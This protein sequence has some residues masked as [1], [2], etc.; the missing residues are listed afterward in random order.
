[1]QLRTII[2][3]LY[4]CRPPRRSIPDELT[5]PRYLNAGGLK[6]KEK[7][8][9][10]KKEIY[11]KPDSTR[12]IFCVA[13][14]IDATTKLVRDQ[15]SVGRNRKRCS[16]AE[17]FTLAVIV[18]LHV[19]FASSGM[20]THTHSP[21]SPSPSPYRPVIVAVKVRCQI[22][23]RLAAKRNGK[24]SNLAII[25]IGRHLRQLPKV[26]NI[27]RMNPRASCLLKEP[28]MMGAPILS[29]LNKVNGKFPE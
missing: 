3:K 21:P 23:S 9:R 29:I 15:S 11:V 6:E 27:D 28:G 24:L 8:K 5:G 13:P 18:H 7:K 12:S 1:M 16:R 17:P 26:L 22:N 4:S 20:L 25:P 14:Q 19:L 10:N 2:K